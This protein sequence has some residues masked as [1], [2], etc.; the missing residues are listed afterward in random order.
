MD[1]AGR[2]LPGGVVLGQQRELELL[3]VASDGVHGWNIEWVTGSDTVTVGLQL[4]ALVLVLHARSRSIT[5]RPS[6]TVK[7]KKDK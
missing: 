5:A 6:R 4:L 7:Q 3:V 1:M 2:P